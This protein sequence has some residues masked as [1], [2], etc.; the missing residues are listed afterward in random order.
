M[1]LRTASHHVNKAWW[2][3]ELSVVPAVI[4]SVPQKNSGLE[5]LSPEETRRTDGLDGLPTQ[6]PWLLGLVRC[7]EQPND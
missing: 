4:Q 2:L 1:S 3:V 6:D 7:M 5:F